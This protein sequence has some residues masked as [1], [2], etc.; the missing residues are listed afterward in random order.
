MKLQSTQQMMTVVDDF[1]IDQFINGAFP[2]L[3]DKL[4]SY[5]CMSNEDYANGSLYMNHVSS[6]LNFSEYSL[7]FRI[8]KG[9]WPFLTDL[10]RVACGRGLIEPGVYLIRVS[11]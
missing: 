4:G 9:Q 3:K 8:A 1:D 2:E 7:K 10:L 11:Y 5:E 6:E